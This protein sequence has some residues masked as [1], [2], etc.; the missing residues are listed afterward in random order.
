MK[1]RVV[2]DWSPEGL[3]GVELYDH[4]TE[5]GAAEALNVADSTPNAVAEHSAM[6]RAKHVQCNASDRDACLAV[7]FALGRAC[8]A[9]GNR[10]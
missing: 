5:A 1:D 9:V 2:A 10:A 7:G 8:H 4:S 6:L 3:V